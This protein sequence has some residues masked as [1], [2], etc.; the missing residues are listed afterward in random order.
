MIRI[1]S[2]SVFKEGE[3]KRIYYESFRA[4]YH[5]SNETIERWKIR[6]GMYY[7]EITGHNVV[8]YVRRRSKPDGTIDMMNVLKSTAFVLN[9]D[10]NQ[11]ISK[12]RKPDIVNVRR[13]A[14]KILF[15]A[16]FHEMDIERGLPFKHRVVYHYIDSIESRIHNQPGYAT[17]YESVKDKVMQMTKFK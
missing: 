1:L 2:I 5:D 7:E 13:V 16:D 9:Q 8:V 14:A 15:D 6:V 10:Y 12:S 3:N 17:A 4:R 11:V